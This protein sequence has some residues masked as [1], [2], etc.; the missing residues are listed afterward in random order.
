MAL[1]KFRAPNLPLPPREYNREQFD[2]ILR[3]LRLYFNQ[4]DSLTPNQ[5]QSYRADQFIGGDYT[6]SN[7]TGDTATF[8]SAIIENLNAYDAYIHQATIDELRA[9]YAEIKALLANRI[10]ASSVSASD[11]YGNFFYGSGRFLI[12]PYNQ[13]L[14]NVDQTFTLGTAKAVELEVTNFEDGIFIAGANDDEITFSE[15]GVYSIQYSLSFKSVSNESEFID[16]WIEYNGTDYPD[17]NSRFLIPARKSATDPSYLI[18]VTA[19]TG[20]AQAANDY[21]RVMWHASSTDV[22]ME[23]LPAVTASVGV[24]PDIPATPSA[25]VQV[26]FISAEYPPVKRVAPLPVIGFGQTGTVTV[27]T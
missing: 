14:S 13:F 21:V 18:A 27:T 6:G 8:E 20:L 2:E 11:F 23:H 22:T 3:A 1:E 15:P 9:E 26:N 17:S 4:L 12:T 5:A 25:I 7:F 24:T 10:L 19:I 16:V